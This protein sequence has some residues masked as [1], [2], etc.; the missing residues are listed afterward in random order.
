MS[1]DHLFFTF[2]KETIIKWINNL[3][4][5]RLCSMYPYPN[6]L[7]PVRF[8][9]SIRFENEEELKD[10]LK[11]IDFK[12]DISK[13]EESRYKEYNE[14]FSAGWVTIKD[15][16]CLMDTNKLLKVIIIEVSGVDNDLFKMDESV[17]QRTLII[18]QHLQQLSLNYNNPPQD[19][20]Y[21]I[22]PELYPDVFEKS[23]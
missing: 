14:N 10:I 23:K 15:Q 12:I 9:A 2:G 5:F 4:I 16:F 22:A 20:R 18:E 17:F 21:C 13:P 11:K 3:K 7:K 8:M 6:D 19:D 1:L